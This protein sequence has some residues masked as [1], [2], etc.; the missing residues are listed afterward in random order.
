MA[1]AVIGAVD[2]KNPLA[3]VPSP[4]H[5]KSE[6]QA[7]GS[8]LGQDSAYAKEEGSAL[9][10]LEHMHNHRRL[11]ARQISFLAIAGT[12]G[13]A[14]FVGIGT[15]LRNGGPGSL[16][17][18]FMIWSSVIWS[19]AQCQIEV[20][21]M[22]PTDGSFIRNAGRFVDESFGMAAGYNYVIN[23][24]AL[25]CFDITAFN[26]LIAYWK[27][28]IHPAIF[29]SVLI[30]LFFCLNIWTVSF[31]GEAEFWL[32][33]GKVSL[34]LMLLFYTIV[35]MCGG[36]PQGDA[37]GFR[38]W[39]DPGS[40]REYINGG[41]LGRFQGVLA[42]IIG[43]AFVIAGP[44]YISMTA[45]EAKN[46]R[47]TMP[48]AFSSITYRLVFFF[49]AGAISV[50]V[51]CPYDA[52]ELVGASGVSAANSPYVISMRRLGI[53]VLPDIVNALIG[54]SIVSAANGYV[55]TTSRSLYSLSV[56]GQAPRFLNKLNRNGVPYLCVLVTIALTGL[57]YLSVS[58]GTAKV[59]NWWI[60]LVTA[61]QLLNWIIMS[62]TWIRF[63]S[64]IKAQGLD[65][66]TFLP[67]RSR[68]QPYCAWYAL[69]WA[70]IILILSGYTLFYPGA[71]KVDEFIFTYGMIFIYVALFIGWKVVK[72]TR[73]LRGSEIDLVSDLQEYND[74]TEDFNQREADK[75]VT[76][77]GRISNKLF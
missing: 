37:F 64:A 29:I 13:A 11:T 6:K 30:F 38:Y 61:S 43:A 66:K 69:T 22:F 4:S 55:F 52:P 10:V 39:R 50:G 44:E 46:P 47:K 59:L 57:S 54:T 2:S 53:S 76:L 34:V 56:A 5:E 45:G 23:Q 70:T 27:D 48:R 19:V 8:G 68:F 36:N 28:D 41:S 3:G 40:F 18:G 21:T 63:N 75:P 72:R 9:S 15:S 32:A 42:T 7:S 49:I 12:I 60:S 17:I 26:T 74:Y 51:L 77:W 16:L 25:A 65:R 31:F 24:A 20:V 1:S 73:W 58:A 71:F 35:T 14:L 67:Y 62:T 33:L